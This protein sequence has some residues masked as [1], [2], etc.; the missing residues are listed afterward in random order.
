MIKKLVTLCCSALLSICAWS[1]DCN[2]SIDETAGTS[3]FT[4]NGDGTITDNTT[5]LMWMVCSLGQTWSTGACSGDATLYTWQEALV[6]AHGYEFADYAGWRVPNIKELA[7]I[8]E[9]SCVRPAIN[10]TL[11][12]S[13]PS[14]DFWTSTPS[15]SDATRTWVI[16]FYN[17]SNAL[18][19]KTL[20]VYV[21]LVRNAD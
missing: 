19:Q 13:T 7:T 11:F 17:S 1:Q 9:R 12:P 15:T 16:A 2:S 5:G 6:A 14:D 21:R 18:K 10:E 4:V 3:N 20:S 8:S